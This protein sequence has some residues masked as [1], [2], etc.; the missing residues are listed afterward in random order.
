MLGEL[1]VTHEDPL[2][3]S[4]PL[5]MKKDFIDDSGDEILDRT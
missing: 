3:L 1:F 4:Q 5:N 2:I